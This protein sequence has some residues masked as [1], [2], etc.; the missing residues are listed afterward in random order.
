MEHQ[1]PRPT[2]SMGFYEL[3][4]EQQKHSYKSLWVLSQC[5]GLEMCPAIS[6][7]VQSPMC[8]NGDEL[9][10]PRDIPTKI[11]KK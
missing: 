4:H 6:G 5:K 7:H 9:T 8:N 3:Y 11:K 1:I 10:N 2:W